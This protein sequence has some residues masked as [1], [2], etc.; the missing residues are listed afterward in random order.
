MSSGH[1][2]T[3]TAQEGTE[4]D[5][6]GTGKLSS[7]IEPTSVISMRTRFLATTPNLHAFEERWVRS[8]KEE[9]LSKLMLVGEASLKKAVPRQ[10][11][12]APDFNNLGVNP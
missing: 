9:C 5:E 12:D 8:V 11:C 4:L 2:P 10:N 6:H 1:T 3:I 7:R